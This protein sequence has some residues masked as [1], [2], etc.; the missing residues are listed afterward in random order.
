MIQKGFLNELDSICKLKKNR[1]K[2]N[3]V[4]SLKALKLRKSGEGGGGITI[5][6]FFTLGQVRLVS[7]G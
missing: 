1:K 3:L 7:H 4:F 6:F 5:S 2:D